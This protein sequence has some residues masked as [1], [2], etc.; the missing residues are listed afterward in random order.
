MSRTSQR[1]FCLYRADLCCAC[2]LKQGLHKQLFTIQERSSF[3]VVL[4]RKDLNAAHIVE[5]V[6][7]AKRLLVADA[8]VTPADEAPQ[9]TNVV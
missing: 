9:L 1:I 4:C 6:I 3:R 2:V 5:Q 8:S 7:M